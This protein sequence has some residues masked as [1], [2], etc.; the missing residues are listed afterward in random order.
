M[1]IS[2]KR[3]VVYEAF[4]LPS[5]KVLIEPKSPTRAILVTLCMVEASRPQGPS[6]IPSS[7]HSLYRC[8]DRTIKGELFYSFFEVKTYLTQT[9][10]DGGICSM[11][12]KDDPKL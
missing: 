1:K 7:S 8:I 10:V 6:P 5:K 9:S 3:G 12:K 2:F 4:N 11:Q